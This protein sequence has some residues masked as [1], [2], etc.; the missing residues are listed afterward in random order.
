MRKG[1]RGAVLVVTLVVIA[2]ITSILAV[3]AANQQ[4][5]IKAAINR[6]EAKRAR[7]M[8]ESGIQRALAELALLESTS[9]VN[10]TGTWYTLGNIGDDRFLVGQDSFR[11]QLIDAGSLINLNTAPELQLEAIGLTTEQIESLLDWREV[12]DFPRTE[13]AKD[14]YYTNLP[15]PYLCAQAPLQTFDEL[16]LIKGFTPEFLYNPLIQI[17]TPTFTD[18]TGERTLY[19]MSTVDSGSPNQGPN[20]QQKQDI[21]TVQIPQLIQSGISPQVAAAIIA[22]RGGG[23]SGMGAVLRVP[24]ITVANA[25]VLLD[26]FTVGAEARST[27]K[28]NVNL[29]SLEVL[30]TLPGITS[31]IADGIISRQSSGME[32]LSELL[33]IPGLDLN[34]LAEFID[35]L[36]LGSDTFIVR[37]EGLA[38]QARITLEAVIRIDAQGPRV[39]KIYEAP[40]TDLRATW[41]WLDDTT[42]E[43]DLGA[44]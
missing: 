42:T 7:L 14:E 5:A 20:G 19:Q 39:L 43:I 21:N 24:G 40:F 11:M 29:A 4:T 30:T 34:T 1:Q 12:G 35:Q 36:T 33:T 22:S 9:S 37:V 25:Q 8:A 13:G 31:E 18:Q 26:S 23:F 2:A 41:G 44:E 3:M 27:G 38:G 15:E 16:L 6:T 17:G 10:Q 32:A 28:T